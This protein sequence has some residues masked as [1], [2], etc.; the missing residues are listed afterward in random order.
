MPHAGVILVVEVREGAN[1]IRDAEC[2]ANISVRDVRLS[3]W[4]RRVGRG[5]ITES[6]RLARLPSR[7]APTGNWHDAEVAARIQSGIHACPDCRL[8][9]PSL[10]AWPG[11]RSIAEE[12]SIQSAYRRNQCHAPEGPSI[13]E[14]RCWMQVRAA[15]SAMGCA[16]VMHYPGRNDSVPDHPG[17]IRG[18]SAGDRGV[19]EAA[20]RPE[21]FPN[22]DLASGS[23]ST[24]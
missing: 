23:Q 17:D 11:G 2:S 8:C 19:G 1:G 22:W 14:Y 3:R 4:R 15:T 24:R 13:V 21:M 5:S 10:S 20:V 6:V 12:M 18:R 7:T 16:G 9:S